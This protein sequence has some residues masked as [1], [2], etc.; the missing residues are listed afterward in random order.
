MVSLI[1]YGRKRLFSLINELPTV[2]EIVTDRKPIKDNKPA[3]DSGSKSR[4][5]TKVSVFPSLVTHT[6]FFGSFGLLDKISPL[7]AEIQ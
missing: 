1:L 4:G 2:F 5:S 3:A 6:C 7:F